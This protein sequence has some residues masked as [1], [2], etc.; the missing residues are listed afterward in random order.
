MNQA[1]ASYIVAV[2]LVALPHAAVAAD[3]R[4]DFIAERCSA[5]SKTPSTTLA[6]KISQA[7]VDEYYLF[8]GHE[9]D[10]DG[11]I[12]A[13]GLVETE[14]HDK[15][16]DEPS[17]LGDMGWWH[18]LKYWRKLSSQPESQ[19][20]LRVYAGA[21][22][23][24]VADRPAK[25][26]EVERIKA[27]KR[28]DPRWKPDENDTTFTYEV[29]RRI[30]SIK[31][32]KNTIEFFTKHLLSDKGPERARLL[33]FDTGMETLREVTFRSAIADTPWSA[34]FISYVV[35]SAAEQK[36]VNLLTREGEIRGRVKQGDRSF[37]T[38]SS[39]KDY[40]YQAMKASVAEAKDSGKGTAPRDNPLYR[41]CP[42]AT[43]PVRR[44]DMV[45]YHREGRKALFKKKSSEEV[46]DILLADIDGK[47]ERL[48]SSH[49]DVVVDIKDTKDHGK[50]AYVIGGNVLQSVT[51]KQLS[52]S[53]TG[54][55]REEQPCPIKADEF[56]RE[57]TVGLVKNDKFRER[58]GTCSL[59]DSHWFAV[60]QF[61]N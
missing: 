54:A 34:A 31:E 53:P 59:N 26:I 57:P 48:V 28:A 21:S 20:S 9:M 24:T 40:I 46:R 36:G 43:A 30:E 5:E 47:T 25:D 13:F 18:V 39:H 55:L 41:L 42:P 51:V 12:A 4:W 16:S 58:Q 60:L 14:H 22:R 56:S 11:R 49:C 33:D 7:A 10:G 52:L 35:A 27:K 50:R 23:T 19:L 6:E 37:R 15:P 44:G 8:G 2:A 29:I 3:S 1:F 38:S 45:C 32:N 61:R 17:T